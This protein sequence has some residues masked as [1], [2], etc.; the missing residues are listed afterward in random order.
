MLHPRPLRFER[1]DNVLAADGSVHTFVRNQLVVKYQ[2]AQEKVILTPTGPNAGAPA[3]EVQVSKD[4]ELSI[5]G[6]K[7]FCAKAP[8]NLTGLSSEVP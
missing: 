5:D 3:L 6:T 7:Y 1:V 8:E 4:G 2:R